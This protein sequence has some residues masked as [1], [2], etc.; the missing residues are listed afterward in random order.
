MPLYGLPKMA[1]IIDV[2]SAIEIHLKMLYPQSF[3]RHFVIV[4]ERQDLRKNRVLY[5]DSWW[6]IWVILLK[7]NQNQAQR[8]KC[9][10]VDDP[11]SGLMMGSA[12]LSLKRQRQQSKG[13]LGPFFI[14]ATRILLA[15]V[16]SCS[17]FKSAPI[18]FRVCPSTLFHQ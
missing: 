17:D 3:G 7:L 15:S 10:K 6:N 1:E 18:R 5:Q 11:K 12:A 9:I 2:T 4:Y 16:T 14:A 8:I 13:L